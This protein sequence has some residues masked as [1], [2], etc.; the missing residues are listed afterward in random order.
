[1]NKILM[2]ALEE[3]IYHEKL[4]NGLNVYI[5][6]KEGFSKKGAYFVTHYGSE[7]ND[8]K[9]IDEDEIRSFPKG[10][11]H[12]LEHKLFES[13][14]NENT[15]NKFQKYGADVNA[16]T[17]HMVT[18]YY[19]TTTENFNECLEELLDFVQSPHFTYK[20]VEKE[21]GIIYQEINMSSDN[22]ERFMFEEGFNS[23]LVNNPNKYKT[24]GDKKNVSMITK[25]DLDK[26]YNTFY[27]PSNM[28]LVIYGD[29]DVKKTFDIVKTNQSKK[30]F[31]KSSKIEIKEFSEPEK[32]ANKYVEFN[33]NV[34]SSKVMIC[35]KI[36]TSNKKDIDKFKYNLFM[37]LF[38][39]MKFG[40]TST[41]EKKLLKSNIIKSE[42]SWTYSILDG[43]TLLFIEASLDNKDKFIELVD[44]KIK[45]IDFEEKIFNLNKKAYITSI[46]RAFENPSGVATIIFNNVFKYGR[47][48]NE[49][50]EIYN[51]YSYKEFINSFNEMNLDNK[52]I[53]VVKNNKN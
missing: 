49:A 3:E 38:M 46:V 5:Y 13:S 2:K 17:N 21:K 44:K 40:G 27:H 30:K 31:L 41:F 25:E 45:S 50:Y 16:Y 12:F 34:S 4:E 26:C 33:K 23:T 32:V 48:L 53:I 22:I 9:P 51:D 43:V 52:S 6:K 42:I 39:E 19:F 24:I 7:K 37:G 18:N 36:L 47:V 8:F 11:A 20:N 15:F 35:Y 10:I 1:M 29:V 28:V 14:D